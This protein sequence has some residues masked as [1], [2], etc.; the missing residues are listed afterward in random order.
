MLNQP[1]SSGN[2]LL[3]Q[4]TSSIAAAALCRPTSSGSSLLH[5]LPPPA[6]LCCSNLP[7]PT[8]VCC[9]SLPPP[10]TVCWTSLYR[11]WS[12][13]VHPVPYL[14]RQ[15]LLDKLVHDAVARLLSPSEC[16]AEPHA[17]RSSPAC[18]RFPAQ[19]CPAAWA[20]PAPCFEPTIVR[21]PWPTR[22]C[23]A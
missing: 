9:T 10:T 2:R 7:P 17:P 14:L 16:P 12:Y 22:C 11:T 21:N 18:D 4:P 20:S 15:R 1:T 8:T 3:Q 19:F 6:V 23:T 5:L 13:A